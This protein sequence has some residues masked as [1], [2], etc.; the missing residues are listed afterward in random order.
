MTRT[1]RILLIIA[2]A[3]AVIGG[4]LW[5]VLLF[6]GD[7]EPTPEEPMVNIVDL[8]E[9]TNTAPPTNV[10][11]P[12]EPEPET[13]T[14]TIPVETQ[15]KRLARNFAERY[16]TFSNHNDF[17]NLENLT[18][19]MT[20]SFKE[21]TEAFVEERR[22][23]VDPDAPYYGITTKVLSVSTQDFDEEGGRMVVT[24]ETRRSE[25]DTAAGTSKTFEENA[26]LEFVK[27]NERWLV[28]SFEFTNG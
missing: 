13:P 15:L 11:E 17:E 16:G 5:L 20:E 14:S 9:P 6:T 22:Q 7:E 24:F 25:T 21:E 4:A 8:P 12:Q 28:N 27:E 23:Q 10:A 3:I 18:G 19:F 1:Q 26:E 2:I